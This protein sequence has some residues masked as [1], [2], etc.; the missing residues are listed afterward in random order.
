MRSVR[1]AQVAGMRVLLR[2]DFNVPIKDGAV[3]DDSR[4]TAVLPTID[5][6]RE[7]GAAKILILT[8]LGRPKDTEGG[9]D[10]APVRAALATLTDMGIV[11]LYENLRLDPGEEANDPAFA[12][13]LARMGDIYINDA[14]AVS[15]RAHASIVGVPKLLP[16]YAGLLL[17]REVDALAAALTPPPHSL[18][19]IGG[20]KFETKLPLIQKLLAVYGEL[21]LGG[22][23]GNDVIKAR[24]MPFGTSLVSQEP[25]PVE[26]ASDER[27]Y[28]PVDAVVTSAPG[29]E[30]EAIVA[31]IRAHERIIDIGPVTAESWR[32][33]IAAAP[34]VLWN[35]PM[36]VYEEGYTDGT[37]VLAEA[38]CKSGVRA[39]VGGG[40]TVAALKKFSFNTE[41]VF[42]STG[43][44]AM[45]E[46]LVA[47]TLPGLDVLRG[48]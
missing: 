20:A 48:A 45:L 13:K 26:V 12:Q 43:G 40:D 6:L 30:R 35:G 8:H 39:I 4:I 44:G 37:D 1:D 7:K 32:K 2:V 10:L 17:L 9:A 38:L 29:A 15:H 46:Y 47:G 33:K 28:A 18:A 41:N 36:G 3:V 23:L 5:L 11:E 42:L 19:I 21:L 31:D 14:F 25:V 16:S 24:G 34:F 22:A 27:L